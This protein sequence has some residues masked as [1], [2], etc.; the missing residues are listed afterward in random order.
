[1]SPTNLNLPSNSMTS[2]HERA[3]PP[4]PIKIIALTDITTGQHFKVKDVDSDFILEKTHAG[5]AGVP[6]KVFFECPMD[7]CFTERK[8]KNLRISAK[9]VGTSKNTSIKINNWSAY[10]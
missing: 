3:C 6:T 2:I 10:E 7:D 8:I 9:T 4:V 5:M 1:M